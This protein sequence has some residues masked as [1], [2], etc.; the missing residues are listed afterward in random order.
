M[1]YHH[2]VGEPPRVQGFV[3]TV[4]LDA[5]FV[6]VGK[7]SGSSDAGEA[8]EEGEGDSQAGSA[9]AALPPPVEAEPAKASPER[10]DAFQLRSALGPKTKQAPG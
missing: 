10:A 7:E 9:S 1:A 8:T 6:A 5:S 2:A 4:E 3:D